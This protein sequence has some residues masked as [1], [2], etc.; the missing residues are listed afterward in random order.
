M[1]K[2]P[3][4][5]ISLISSSSS[6]VSGVS[7]IMLVNIAEALGDDMEIVRLGSHLETSQPD[8]QRYLATNRMGGILTSKGTYQ[9]LVDWRNR[10]R[11]QYQQTELR[12]ALVSSCFQNVADRYL[13]QGRFSLLNM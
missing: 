1:P 11:M 9:M 6:S 8:I 10:T 4:V 13:P 12:E 5:A 3:L 2:L 7:D